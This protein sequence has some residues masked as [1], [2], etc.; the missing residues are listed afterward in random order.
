M[1]DDLEHDDQGRDDAKVSAIAAAILGVV[2]A[3]VAGAVAGGQAALSVVI[4]A[5]IAVANLVMMRAIVRALMPP[6]EADPATL[7]TQEGASAPPDG[8]EGEDDPAAGDPDRPDPEKA[9]RRGGAAW[10]VFAL[11]KIGVLFGGIWFLLTRGW[12]DPIPLV[13]GYGVLP[14]GIATSALVANLSPRRR[15]P[16]RRRR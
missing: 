5:A 15:A 1:T 4:G 2:F 8:T 3:A 16:G 10:G 7:P 13:V 6:P 14:L 9:G 11:L 12:V